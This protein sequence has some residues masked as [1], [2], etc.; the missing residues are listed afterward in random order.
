[1]SFLSGTPR[2]SLSSANRSLHRTVYISSHCALIALCTRI[3][4]FALFPIFAACHDADRTNPFDPQ[5]TPAV[6]LRIAP[7]DTAGTVSLTWTR[8]AGEQAFAKYRIL[9]NIADR[10]AVDTLARIADVEQLAFVDTALDLNTA[11]V[12]RV[13]VV[14]ASGFEAHSPP[15]PISPLNLPAVD[16]VDLSFNSTTATATLEWTPYQGPR[17]ASYQIR[18]SAA[19]KAQT[20][21][22]IADFSTTSLVDS[23]LVGNTEYT[24]QT[25]VRTLRDEEIAGATASGRF[26]PLLTTWPLDLVGRNAPLEVVRLSARSTPDGQIAVQIARGETHLLLFDAEG[27]LLEEQTLRNWPTSSLLSS[28]YGSS[29]ERNGAVAFDPEGQRF[30]LK[31]Q[32]ESQGTIS[33]I[34]LY[35]HQGRPLLQEHAFFLDVLPQPLVGEEGSVAGEVVLKSDLNS[36]AFFDNLLLSADGSPLLEED[37]SFLPDGKTDEE[38]LGA[39][40]FPE[41][42]HELGQAGIYGVD[43]WLL[44]KGDNAVRR[45]EPAWGMWQNFRLEVDVI[46]PVRNGLNSIQIGGHTYSRFALSFNWPF[47]GLDWSFTPPPASDLAPRAEQFATSFPMLG[48]LT[49]FRLRL[50]FEAGAFGAAL[51]THQ[52][53]AQQDEALDRIIWVSLAA[54]GDGFAFTVEDR[55]YHMDADGKVELRGNLTS[56]ASETR[57]WNVDGESRPRVGV[58]LP[59]EDRVAWGTVISPSRW[60]S[61]LNNSVGPR[62]SRELGNLFYPLSMDAAPDGRIYV[63]DAGNARILVFDKDGEY[64]TQWG[65]PGD[66]PGEFNFG[67]GLPVAQGFNLA[68]SIA[69]DSQG[70]IYVADVFNRRIQKFAP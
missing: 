19:G 66:A 68:G 55:A 50:Q 36:D 28:L 9:R 37:F 12:Y 14:N 60:N 2:E 29:E 70:Y 64:I 58:C 23:N 38:G 3:L 11:Y 1:M 15:H 30:L 63:L 57:V 7:D 17:F 56:A 10:I 47:L 5:L 22:E 61:T 34:L 33:S 27:H 25:A 53:W 20:I 39:W 35:D 59:D 24:Y 42:T 48:A 6:D 31:G 65:Q 4:L 40:F 16:I 8:Y 62:L 26:H 69:V 51:E 49:P 46:G 45:A 43:G 21:A 18:R 32:M 41:E 54:L 52:I 67:D 44:L 13:S